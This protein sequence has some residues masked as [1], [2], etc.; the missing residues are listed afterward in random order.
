MSHEDGSSRVRVCT[1]L[2]REMVGVWGV[3]E[4][5]REDA[6]GENEENGGVAG[7]AG[8]PPRIGAGGGAVANSR[9]SAISMPRMCRMLMYLSGSVLAYYSGLPG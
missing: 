1:R 2:E 9:R 7:P 5:E 4:R 6:T 3:R 8:G